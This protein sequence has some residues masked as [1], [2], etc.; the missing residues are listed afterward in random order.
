MLFNPKLHSCTDRA[1]E[2][3]DKEDRANGL[4]E[5]ANGLLDNTN[6]PLDK[7]S[8]ATCSWNSEESQLLF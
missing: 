7:K 3:L 4:L 8:R 1:N 5:R 2:L 6:G